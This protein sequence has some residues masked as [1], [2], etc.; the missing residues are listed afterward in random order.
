V[1]PE[2]APPDPDPPD[3]DP[4]DPDPSAAGAAA[5]AARSSSGCMDKSEPPPCDAEPAPDATQNEDGG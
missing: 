1:P 2:P 5:K 3:P 4:P